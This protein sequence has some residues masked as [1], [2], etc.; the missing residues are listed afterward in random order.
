MPPGRCTLELFVGGRWTKAA[1]LHV[2]ETSA[3]TAS[4][5]RI[6]YD[7]AYLDALADA[8][9]ARDARAVSCRHPLGYADF[10][11][12][13]WPAFLLDLL[14]A[15]AARRHW[16]TR[17]GLPNAPR[18]DWQVLVGG[19]GNPPGNARVAEAV[20]AP[21]A[22]STHPGFAR[23]D[24]VDRA[25][26]FVEYARSAGAPVSGSTGAGGD[27]PKF[28]L[29]EDVR[30]RWHAD[31]ALPDERTRR[32]WLVKFPR[33]R[34]DPSDRL[35]LRAE[36]G[37]HRVA[38]RMGVR[39]SG[40]VEWEG[41]CL[42]CER[43]DRVVRG[44]RVERLG[45][46]SLHSLAGVAG[47][48]AATPKEVLATAL[49]RFASDPPSELRE[50]L[51][52][53]VLD[54]A[55]GNTDNHGRNT[56]VL[57][58][59]KGR[60]AL[61]PVYDFAPMILDRSGIARVSRWRDGADYPQWSAVADALGPL[62]LPPAETRRWLRSLAPKVRKLPATMRACEVPPAVIEA[63]EPRVRHVSEAL[64]ALPED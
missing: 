35:V 8:L 37:Y 28:L 45:L 39:A 19:A 32:C 31:G 57:K 44:R 46:E 51:L 30:G 50:L 9:S 11:E 29:R 36:A 59:A 52:G 53:D 47:F 6:A 16:E 34:A 64:A 20:E 43:F 41:D 42:F 48:G 60:V 33:N 17:L 3:G 54:V 2:T 5:S 10:L 15:G 56:S 4:P 1:T 13:A 61:S 38:A 23:R 25:E 63:C 55:M 40:R 18:S 62:G 12:P 22:P 7:F 49:A 58:D 21:P 26:G 27:S 24:V 14:P